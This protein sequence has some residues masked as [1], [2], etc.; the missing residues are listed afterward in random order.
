MLNSIMAWFRYIALIMLSLSITVAGL[1]AQAKSQCP[2]AMQMQK[3][4]KEMD[5]DCKGCAMNSKQEP[6]KNGC[7]DNSACTAK[8]SSLGSVASNILPDA[9][10]VPQFA[11]AAQKFT[12]AGTVPPSFFLNTQERPPKHLS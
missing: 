11:T 6:K 8:C 2:M 1:P 5:K 10:A 7:C 4:T 12:M 3:M 9:V